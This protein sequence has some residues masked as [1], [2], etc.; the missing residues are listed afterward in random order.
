MKLVIN[1]ERA[2]GAYRLSALYCALMTSD[3]PNAF[4]QPVIMYILFFWVGG[5]GGVQQ[6]FSSLAIYVLHT[7]ASY[8]SVMMLSD[9]V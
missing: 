6:F 7:W 8:V 1:K 4:L 9:K 5:F 3:L 2:S